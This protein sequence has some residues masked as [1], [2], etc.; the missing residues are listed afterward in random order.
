MDHTVGG[1]GSYMKTKTSILRCFIGTMK[2]VGVSYQVQ[3]IFDL[4]PQ[5]E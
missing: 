2:E 5:D 1:K 3:G 4:N